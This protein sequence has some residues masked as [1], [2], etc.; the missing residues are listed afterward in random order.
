MGKRKDLFE[1]YRPFGYAPSKRFAGPGVGDIPTRLN[2]VQ[3]KIQ[4]SFA[5]T[6]KRFFSSLKRPHR[7]GA[8]TASYSMGKK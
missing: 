1:I 2:A 7:S 8:H 6:G 3:S 5:G 4:V